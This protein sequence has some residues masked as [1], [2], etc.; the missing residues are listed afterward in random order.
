MKALKSYSRGEQNGF[1][2]FLQCSKGRKLKVKIQADI[3]A[4]HYCYPFCIVL[5][6]W[7]LR[8]STTSLSLL[9]IIL[10]IIGLQYVAIP[11]I[12]WPRM[13]A[14]TQPAYFLMELNNFK[15]T[16]LPYSLMCIF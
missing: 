8:T 11:L 3:R 7:N 2:T 15:V 6:M 12:D 9:I 14:A 16:C 5:L 1:Y 4:A 13:F 10:I